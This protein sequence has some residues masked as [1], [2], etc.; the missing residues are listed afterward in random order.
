M[1][2]QAFQFRI[3][4]FLYLKTRSKSLYILLF[5]EKKMCSTR[6]EVIVTYLIWSRL[7]SMY[8]NKFSNG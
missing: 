6:D 5:T 4:N 7:C 3:Y 2:V 8:Q 1:H